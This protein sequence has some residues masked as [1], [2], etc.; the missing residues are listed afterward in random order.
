MANFARVAVLTALVWPAIAT[1]QSRLPVVELTGTGVQ[2]GTAVAAD[3]QGNSYF[4]GYTDSST[5]TASGSSVSVVCPGGANAFVAKFSGAAQT[6]AWIRCI[7][8]SW[9][10]RATAIAV[11]SDA[12]YLA[13]TTNSPDFPARQGTTVTARALDGFVSKLS[14]DGVTVAWTVL[15]GGTS[16]DRI[17]SL[18]LTA[19]GDLDFGG[20]TESADLPVSHAIRASLSG[21][22]D[23]L[24]GRMDASGQ[25]K[26]LTYVGGSGNDSVIAVASDG[27]GNEYAAGSTDSSDFPTT[28]N[29]LRKTRPGSNNGF[30]CKLALDGSAF[31]YSTYLSGSQGVVP[32]WERPGALAVSLAGIAYVG[33]VTAS[34]DFPVVNAYQTALKSA[35]PDAYVAA[36]SADGS[37]L[38]F[39]TYLG[40]SA[41]DSISALAFNERAGTITVA[42][43]TLSSDFPGLDPS[44]G[45]FVAVF[46][47]T[48]FYRGVVS[49][50]GPLYD[51]AA[52]A[53]NA[54]SSRM[55]VAGSRNWSGSETPRAF[56]GSCVC[57]PTPGLT[58]MSD[59]T[60]QVTLHY[61]GGLG[62][63]KDVGW[64]WLNAGGAA[65]WRVAAIA[66]FN[67]DG[68]P[69]LV[70]V[71][72]ATRQVTL[73]YYGGSTGA[74]YQGWS[75]MNASGAAGWRVVAA[76]DFN[77]D[78]VP[79]LVWMNDTTRQVT[80]HYYG[81]TGGSEYQGW[82]WLNASGAGGWTVVAAADVNG[83]GVPDLLWMNDTTRQ[84]TVHYYGGTGGATYQG[85]NW[86]N[87]SGAAG[88]RVV[89]ASDFNGDGVPDLVWMSDAT[90]QVTLHYYGGT[91]GATYQGWNW[92]SG[93]VATG[94]SVAA[95]F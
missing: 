49:G 56:I 46:S 69:D 83:D 59:T 55:T 8:G 13:G 58:W 52:L 48:G 65:G 20:D 3:Q 50:A 89:A 84:I 10:D 70:W 94:W 42:G 39:S 45:A 25:L 74:T 5:L 78:G 60:R 71:N 93:A 2:I 62:G 44:Y 57:T 22:R 34:R 33:G 31:V 85:W 27:A 67:R 9:D 35:G 36:L 81:G 26:Y 77:R 7:G 16:D 79:D 6:P 64:N 40:G 17:N 54:S 21:T 30:V 75:W 28:A 38:L 19:A 47:T 82:N 41:S 86:I 18:R 15:I 76:A 88:W 68:V 43:S 87:Q 29:A 73:H 1:S 66:D 95:T 37:K 61:Y 72:D 23:G 32:E 12:I 11:T 14:L 91:G 51:P 92:L 63:A 80:V 24:L 90:R 53:I 4:A